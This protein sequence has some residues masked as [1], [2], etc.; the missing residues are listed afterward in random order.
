MLQKLPN[1]NEDELSFRV[2]LPVPWNRIAKFFHQSLKHRTSPKQY[3][4][5]S[6]DVQVHTILG[7]FLHIPSAPCMV[8]LST[9]TIDG[10]YTIHGANG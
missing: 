4:M 2:I 1:P 7:V 9:F 10:I 5:E 8:Y 3:S 6:D